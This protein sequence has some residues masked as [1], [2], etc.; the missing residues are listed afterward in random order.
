[1]FHK[2][3]N[4]MHQAWYIDQRGAVYPRNPLPDGRKFQIKS[5]MSGYRALY[6]AEHIGG[7]QFRLRIRNNMAIDNK[8]WWI[9]DTRTRS[10][11][12]FSRRNYAISNQ[13]GY[14]YRIGV[15]AVIRQWRGENYQKVS[16][17]GG[18]RRSLRNNSQKCLDVHGGRNY[19]NRHVIFWNC[20]NGANQ[21]WFID[22]TGFNFPRQPLRDGVK[23]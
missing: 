9:F 8:Q 17:W 20:H 4:G 16:F 3:H 6:W 7:W 18:H 2:C 22:Q 23:F 13:S 15:A 5:R 12:A 19:H 11:R 14:R 21:G 10:I 1:M